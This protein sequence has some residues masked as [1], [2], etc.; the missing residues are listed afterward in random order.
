L[1]AKPDFLLCEA[2]L[3]ALDPRMGDLRWRWHYD[4]TQGGRV[5]L[6]DAPH[7]QTGRA[8]LR[9]FQ[10]LVVAVAVAAEVAPWHTSFDQA[11][12]A[13]VN[14]LPDGEALL[15]PESSV[16]LDRP[17]DEHPCL[18][19]AALCRA[20]HARGPRLD[21]D[22][23]TAGSESPTRTQAPETPTATAAI[24][25]PV[26]LLSN[27]SENVFCRTA[28]GWDIRFRGTTAT[29]QHYEGLALIHTLLQHPRQPLSAEFLLAGGLGASGDPVFDWRAQREIHGELE[30][31]RRELALA[32]TSGNH[33]RVA[34]LK[35]EALELTGHARKG[36]ALARRSRRLG[37]ETER[38]RK[39]ARRRYTT[40]LRA[41]QKVHPA[42]AEHL[43]TAISSGHSFVYEPVTDLS[44]RT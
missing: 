41:L 21:R 5:I 1:T 30:R 19:L 24:V 14:L 35:E 23:V 7:D 12:T 27:A 31:L 2:R 42:L 3:T 38:S 39:T 40:A 29:L 10:D 34:A 25:Q 4:A 44:W 33:E 8:V 36:T 16:S 15:F 6:S 37:A 28:D 17:V 13:L 22:A 32:E 18:A 26:G 20:L 43:K 11:I 9:E